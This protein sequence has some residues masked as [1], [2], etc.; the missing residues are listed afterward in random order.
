MIRNQWYA[1][2]DSQE[3]K[4]GRPVGVTRLGEKLVFWRNQ[5]GTVVCMRDLCPH[6]GARLSMGKVRQDAIACPFH[7]FEYDASGRC[8]YLPAYGRSGVIPKA[9]KAGVYPTHESHGYIWV[10]WGEAES[11]PEAPQF[12]ESIDSSFSYGRFHQ[13]WPVHYSRMAENQLDM[14]HLP[15]V[16]ANSIGRGGRTVVDGPLALLEG[17]LMQIWVFNRL[18][19]G[20]P[21]RKMEELTRPERHPQLE[22]RFPNIWHNWISD[23]V[24]ITVAFVPVDD[25][26]AI[27]YGRFYQRVMRLP[28]LREVVNWV[29]NISGHY[30]ANQDRVIVSKQWPKKS[31]LKMGEKMMQSD[32]AILTY[33]QHRRKLQEAAGQTL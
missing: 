2:L 26:N 29:G 1:V 8:T 9:L 19:D 16:H 31:D 18:D 30:I 27:M 6:I 25:E 3:V 22:F 23:D 12:F 28:I 24:R 33:R 7:G 5:S 15:F 32:R 10:Y 11:Q 13:K 21:A 17:D 4:S 14:T 20:T